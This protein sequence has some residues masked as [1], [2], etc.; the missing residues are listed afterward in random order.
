MS[1]YARIV[2]NVAVDVSAAPYEHFHPTLA[3]EFVEVP[4]E[5]QAGWIKVE[6]VW[7]APAA[8]EPVEPVEPVEPQPSY[9]TVGPIHFQMLFTSQE[10]VA[11]EGAR[12]TDPVLNR[13]WKLIEDPRTD[14]VNL[15]LQSVQDAVEYTLTVAKTAGVDVDVQ[16][17]KAEILSGVLQ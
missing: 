9:P 12:A 1:N 10:A 15:G 13:F 6:G 8:L 16:A 11:A 5:V 2:D 4:A 17:R 3:G 7:A 14:V